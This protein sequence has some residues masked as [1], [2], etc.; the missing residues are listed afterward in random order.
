MFLK[1]DSKFFFLHLPYVNI[2]TTN[3]TVKF[4]TL[5]STIY[6]PYVK[7]WQMDCCICASV[8]SLLYMRDMN[9]WVCS[10]VNLWQMG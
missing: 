2:L 5:C 9:P 1:F 6:F 10:Y 7:L 4:R 8:T 3:F